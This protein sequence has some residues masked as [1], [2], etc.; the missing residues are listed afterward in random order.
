MK[1]D[2]NKTVVDEDLVEYERMERQHD[3]RHPFIEDKLIQAIKPYNCV[4]YR[5]LALHINNWCQHTCIA[6]WLNSHDTYSL[7]AK[8]IKPGLTPENQLKQVSFSRRVHG[9]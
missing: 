3:P 2:E 6:K 9:C 8:N 5:Q 1:S 4:S 7:Y